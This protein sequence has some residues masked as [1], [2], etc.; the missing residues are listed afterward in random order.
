MVDRDGIIRHTT[1]P[2]IAGQSRR[3][4]FVFRQAQ[5]DPRD[6]LI[7]GTPIVSQVGQHEFL[8]PLGRRLMSPEGVF[9]GAI[10]ASF[11]PAETRGFFETVDVGHQGV[12]SVF[13]PEGIILF[14]E[15]SAG[16]LIGQSARENPLFLS[17]LRSG[18]PMSLTN[19]TGPMQAD[20]PTL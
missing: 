20:G 4:D 17:A 9:E 10:V 11:V 16:D 18:T 7:V 8:I 2:E 1:L 3:D 19:L 12:V 15:P 14:R 6:L 5:V 13:H